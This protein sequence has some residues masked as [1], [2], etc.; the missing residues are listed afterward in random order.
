MN[1]SATGVVDPTSATPLS[2]ARDI[3]RE[4]VA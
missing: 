1:L 2:A 4:G 3:V